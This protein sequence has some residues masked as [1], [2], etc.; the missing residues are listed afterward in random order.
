VLE[1]CQITRRDLTFKILKR[2]GFGYGSGQIR[3]S[4]RGYSATT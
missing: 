1:I 4:K 2:S 3:A